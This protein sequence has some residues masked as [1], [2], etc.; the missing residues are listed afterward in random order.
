MILDYPSGLNIIITYKRE[1]G[2][3]RF[4]DRDVTI[5]A[6]AGPQGKECEQ[7]LGTGKGK[8]FCP[9]ASKRNRALPTQLW[10]SDLQNSQIISLCC[11][12]PASLQ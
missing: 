9:R 10:T 12:K 6:D 3:L 5:P 4:R 2:E 11:F 8:G 7:L 1:A